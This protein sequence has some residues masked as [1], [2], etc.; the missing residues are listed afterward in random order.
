MSN[1][2]YKHP[3]NDEN[4]IQLIKYDRDLPKNIDML[5]SQ[6]IGRSEPKKHLVVIGIDS[7]N[8][9][10]SDDFETVSVISWSKNLSTNNFA[11]VSDKIKIHYIQ[12]P[13]QKYYDILIEDNTLENFK[14]M[15]FF[16]DTATTEIYTILFVGSVRCV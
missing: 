5:N 13:N 6:K 1:L 4:F 15:Y 14:K 2:I 10:F 7:M 9:T 12:I 3:K 8:E 11:T 16:N